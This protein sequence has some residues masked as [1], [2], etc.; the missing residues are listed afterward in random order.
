MNRFTIGQA[1]SETI[2]GDDTYDVGTISAIS[3]SGSRITTNTGNVYTKAGF[4]TYVRSTY[5][6]HQRHCHM[7]HERKT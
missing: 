7:L 3:K 6:L 2:N 4:D 1:V 5:I